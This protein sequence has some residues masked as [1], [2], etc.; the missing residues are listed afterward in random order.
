MNGIKDSISI[1]F[2][3]NAN[4]RDELIKMYN[5]I[6]KKIN[7]FINDNLLEDDLDFMQLNLL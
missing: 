4:E 7:E 1:Y 6:A 2:T 5:E 3:D